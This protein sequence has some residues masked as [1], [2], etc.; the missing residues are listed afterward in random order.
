MDSA[1]II[2]YQIGIMFILI[3]FGF[4]LYKAKFFSKKGCKQLSDFVLTVVCPVL[5]FVSF[6]KEFDESLVSGLI[7]AFAMAFI[8]H[9]V[10]IV[11]GTVL[12]GKRRGNDSVVE[13]FSAAYSNC[14]FLGIPL[15]EA[16]YGTDGIFFLTAYIAVFNILSWTHGV[17][18]M[19]DKIS[20]RSS[21][22]AL[23]APAVIATF[24]GIIFFVLQ[25]S[26]PDII[27]QPL[28]YIAS[29][30]TPL[31]MLISGMTIARS[32]V[33][34][35]LKKSGIYL[36]CFIKL[37]LGPFIIILLFIPFKAD[38]VVSNTMLISAAC[39]TAATS[40]MFAARYGKNSVYASEIFAVSTILSAITLP[41]IILISGHFH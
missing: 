23:K 6:Q 24:A 13:R 4:I 1:K 30:N 15:I 10:F 25:I 38:P 34:S 21:I 32:D 8:S 19:T 27:I 31:A 5:I 37:L 41:I 14:G 36:T 20:L 18:I 26:L 16:I 12:C 2:V 7:T 9:I 40:V 29:L 3:A 33:K 22:N 28:N 11:L 35:A 39:P 17:M